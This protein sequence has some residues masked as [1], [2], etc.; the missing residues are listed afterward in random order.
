MDPIKFKSKS[1]LLGLMAA[2]RFLKDYAVE[3]KGSGER[4]NCSLFSCEGPSVGQLLHDLQF[5]FTIII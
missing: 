5:L 2:Y 3:Q 4:P 1:P